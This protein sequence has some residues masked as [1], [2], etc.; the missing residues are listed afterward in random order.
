M[1][2]KERFEEALNG[3]R[4]FINQDVRRG[5]AGDFFDRETRRDVARKGEWWN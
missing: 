5:R 2:I 1:I 3:V 4:A